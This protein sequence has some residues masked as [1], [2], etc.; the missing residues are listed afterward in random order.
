MTNI[1]VPSDFTP[2]TLKLAEQAVKLLNREVNIIFFHAFSMPFYY[3]DFFRPE[4]QPWQDVVSDEF[5]QGCKQLKEKYPWLIN[6]INFKYMQGNSNALFRNWAEAHEIDIIVC[7][8]T[9]AH[10]KIHERSLNPAGFF[11]K[12]R[13]PL[14][15]EL[16]PAQP[17]VFSKDTGREL[18]GF[19]TVSS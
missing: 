11:K 5:R 18:A 14:L 1:L 6:S 17:T 15:Q 10:T 19:V 12:S 7:P 13:L 8:P 9:Y 3:Q 4:R 16:S 2:A